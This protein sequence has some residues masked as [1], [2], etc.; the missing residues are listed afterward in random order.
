MEDELGDVLF[1]LVN[2]ARKLKIDPE[3]ALRRTNRKFERRF[4]EI[5]TR[6][7]ARGTAIADAPLED[8]EESGTR[9]N[10]KRK[11]TLPNQRARLD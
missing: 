2:L 8:M 5:E 9:L 7:A 6:L 11:T 4:R 3:A 1:V 10:V